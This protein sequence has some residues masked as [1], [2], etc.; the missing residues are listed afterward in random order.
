[1]AKPAEAITEARWPVIVAIVGLTGCSLAL[2][3]ELVLGPRWA[4]PVL[5]GVLVVAT[6]WAHRAAQHHLDKTGGYA[7]SVI[8]TLALIYSIVRLLMTLPSKTEPPA[9]LLKSASVLWVTNLLVFALWYWRLDAGG[10]HARE[11]RGEHTEGAF[12]F[13]QMMPGGDVG[14]GQ[15][16]MPNFIDYLFVAF[17][18]ST[19]L[20]PTDTAIMSR[21]A[22]VLTMVQSLIALVCVGVLV[23]RAVGLL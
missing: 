4:L 12:F 10:P 5:V 19:T 1:V 15:S 9:V 22:K 6:Y 16:W 8:V 17:A 14:G 2:P 21:W 18:T 11:K 7:I 3:D 13:P 20:G 23:S